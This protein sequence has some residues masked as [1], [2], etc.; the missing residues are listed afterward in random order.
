MANR[1]FNQFQQS[2]E[3]GIVNLY[4]SMTIGTSGAIDSSS[5]KGFT[6]AKTSGETG[7]YT[8]TLND[9]YNELKICN[10][11]C[12]GPADAALTDA[13]GIIVSLRNDAVASA[14]TFDIQFSRNTTLA[15]TNP[16]SGI[17]VK[18]EI[19]LKNSGQTF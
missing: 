19:V 9:K 1:L 5:T 6:I 2:L 17:I 14:K 13:S 18:I 16:T 15:D 7:R 10:V 3:S 4:G 8:V 11:V 12:V